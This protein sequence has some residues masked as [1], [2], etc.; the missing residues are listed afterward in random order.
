MKPR[1]D[2]STNTSKNGNVFDD[3]SSVVNFS[4]GWSVEPCLEIVTCCPRLKQSKNVINIP[5]AYVASD[6]M[7][8]IEA[9]GFMSLCD[10]IRLWRYIAA[11]D[12]RAEMAAQKKCDRTI[13][14][15]KVKRFGSLIKDSSQHVL[16]KSDYKLSD[17]ERFALAHGFNFGI[18]NQNIKREDIFAEFELLYAQLS[19][20]QAVSNEA[21]QALRAR[22][23]DLVHAYCGIPNDVTDFHIQ[24]D[25]LLAI[26]GLRRNAAIHICKPDKGTGVVIRKKIDYIDK[27]MDILKDKTRFN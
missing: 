22:L 21:D 12:Q 23:S 11:I 15:L 5:I 19:T 7:P 18:P 16:N 13:D 2:L 24:R 9:R 3:S 17:T 1:L 4:A 8:G 14:W 26:Q 20:Y 27:M 6:A 25:V 10:T